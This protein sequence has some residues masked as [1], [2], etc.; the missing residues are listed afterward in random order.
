VNVVVTG[1]KGYLG[2]EVVARALER[3]HKVVVVDNSST[4]DQLWNHP[5]VTYVDADIRDPLIWRDLLGEVDVVIHLA[6][7]VGDPVCTANPGLAWSTNYGATATLN[8]ACRVAGIH[9]LVFAAT[10]SSYGQADSLA[11]TTSLMHPLSEYAESKLFAEHSL[12]SP[13]DGKTQDALELV[14]LRFATLHGPSSRMRFDLVVNTMCAAAATTGVVQV[15]GGQQWR[16]LLHVSDA[17]D[18]LLAAA[19]VDLT[20]R[21]TIL[22]CGSPREVFTVSEIAAQVAK[23]FSAK[24]STEPTLTDSRSYQVDFS[25]LE[26]A[27]N[28]RPSRGIRDTI[29]SLR[30]GFEEGLW[31]DPW[32][33]T[34]NNAARL[35][36]F[37]GNR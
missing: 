37:V 24:V 32:S 12:L 35:R 8:E 21:Q 16:P 31:P 20:K 4:G 15:H 33:A 29:S 36:D 30:E 17:A 6:A 11:T 13:S 18:A 7:L 23:G 28:F 14:V 2:S 34:F 19:T 1:G 3:D 5:L 25:Q 27:L 26:P 10:C 22:N 9:R